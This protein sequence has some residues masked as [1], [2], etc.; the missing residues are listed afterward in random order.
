MVRRKAIPL[1][2][3]AALLFPAALSAAPWA[4]PE[5][6]P[7]LEAAATPSTPEVLVEWIIRIDDLVACRTAAPDLRRMRHEYQARL[8]LVT[9]AVETDPALV[10]SFLRRELL[11][12]AEV[13]PMTERQFQV[14]F[15]REL[16]S[17]ARTPALLVST[18][19]GT[20]VVFDA[21]VRSAP[22]RRGVD[23]FSA[24][25][26]TLMNPALAGN[27]RSPSASGGR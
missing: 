19:G 18:G 1:I 7:V 9:Y 27:H 13:Q 14:A 11:G 8:R 17:R 4:M 16:G 23:D 10:R 12:R 24:H 6:Q 26:E 3:G 25:V 21:G 22:G 5:G 2:A 20:R 15:G